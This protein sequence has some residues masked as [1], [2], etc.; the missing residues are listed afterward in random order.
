[1]YEKSNDAIDQGDVQ[2][3][4]E[5]YLQ[6]IQLQRDEQRSLGMARLPPSFLL[7]IPVRRSLI[8]WCT[9]QPGED[10]RKLASE[11]ALPYE[12]YVKIFALLSPTEIARLQLVSKVRSSVDRSRVQLIG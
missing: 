11:L 3:F 5:K 8:R 9:I 7:L 2:V 6:A 10:K 12:I 4:V 1:M